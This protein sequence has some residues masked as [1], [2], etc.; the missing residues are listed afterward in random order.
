[1]HPRPNMHFLTLRWSWGFMINS[2]C[3]F[4]FFIY[5]IVVAMCAN[6]GVVKV[7]RDYIIVILPVQTSQYFS[8]NKLKGDD[9]CKTRIV[10]SLV[11]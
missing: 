9:T 11:L 10:L 7:K 8:G 5:N 6:M 2:P 4:A 3:S 1:M